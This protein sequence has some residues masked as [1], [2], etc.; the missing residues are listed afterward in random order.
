MAANVTVS[1]GPIGL[2]AIQSLTYGV[3]AIT[4]DE[5]STQGP[6]F[7]TIEPGVREIFSLIQTYKNLPTKS[8]SGLPLNSSRHIFVPTVLR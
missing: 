2:T 5:F 3:P 8:K 1:P 6:E 7:E 4:N